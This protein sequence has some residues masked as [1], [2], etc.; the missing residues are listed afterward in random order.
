MTRSSRRS[1]GSYTPVGSRRANLYRVM[2]DAWGIN[3]FAASNM[4]ARG[5]VKIDGYTVP[6]PW[7]RGHWTEEQLT[8]R[9]L[10]CMRGQVRL[11]GARRVSW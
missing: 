2:W 1:A 8:G 11:Y 9:M 7:A 4:F 3:S 5:Q 6:A 10:T